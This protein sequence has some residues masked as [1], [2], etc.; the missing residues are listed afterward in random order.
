MRLRNI[1]IIDD[2]L[3]IRETL[4]GVLKDENYKVWTAHNEVETLRVL[5][6]EDI[7]VVFLDILMKP[8]DGIELLKRIKERYSKVIVIMMS[9]HG[10]IETAVQATKL[11]AYHFIEKPLSLEKILVILEN[12]FQSK[13]LEEE[14][15]RLR[16][17]KYQNVDLIGRSQAI[18]KIR[19]F[20]KMVAP[21]NSWVLISG[22]NGTG[23]EMVAR[24]LHH[25]SLRFHREFVAVNCAAIPENLIESELF[26]YEKGAFTGAYSQKKGKFDLADGGTLFLDEIGDMSLHTQSKVLRILQEQKFERVGGTKTIE[27]DVRV[28]AATNKDLKKEIGEGRFREDLY[29]R[30]NVIPFHIPPLRERKE[31]IKPLAHFFLSEIALENNK[32]NI[33]IT[34]RAYERLYQ[35]DWPGNIRELRNLI[36][37]FAIMSQTETIDVEG[38]V[39]PTERFQSGNFSSDF[40]SAR[41]NFEKKFIEEKLKEFNGN[42][43]KTAQSIGVERS[44]LHRKIKQYEIKV[45]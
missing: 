34:D 16:L 25:L 41:E 29:Y 11:G 35:Y 1:L 4:S 8:V 31:D 7:H 42:I 27:V 12:A 40:R 9:G 5:S 10:T 38:V 30:L 13:E 19:E 44:H 14:N 45:D 37:R 17:E 26:G 36:E 39:L 24:N 23:K 18:S 32:G 21:T 43:S 6:Q 3:S 33:K 20:I 15:E 2:E 28:I 22:E